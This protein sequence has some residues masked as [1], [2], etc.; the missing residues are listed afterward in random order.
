[1]MTLRN[2]FGKHVMADALYAANVLY[3]VP[4]H[5]LAQTIGIQL[6]YVE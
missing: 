4:I 2:Q 5:F 3:S 6:L 1:M